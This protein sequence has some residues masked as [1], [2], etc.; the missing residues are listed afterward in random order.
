MRGEHVRFAFPG[1]PSEHRLR[2]RGEEG[3]CSRAA[4]ARVALRGT[5]G[6]AP[7]PGTRA[8]A[9]ARRLPQ[10]D[11]GRTVTVAAGRRAFRMALIELPSGATHGIGTSLTVGER[12]GDTSRQRLDRRRRDAASRGRACTTRGVALRQR[13]VRVGVDAATLTH[14]A[15]PR[16]FPAAVMVHGSGPQH[17]RGVRGLRRVPRVER[18]R[19]ARRRQARRRR[20]RR[21]VPGR[22]GHR[23]DDRHPRAGRA[24]GGALRRDAAADRSE[25]RRSLRRQPGRLD[26]PARGGARA[27]PCA[28]LALDLGPTA[29]V[30]RDRSTGARSPASRET[31]P[32]GTHAEMLAQVRRHGP[33]GFD[34]RPSLAQARDPA[35]SGCSATTTATSRPSSASSGCRR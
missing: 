28:G 31:P 7:R 17:A 9:A 15:R 18:R 2:R 27:V 13:E 20:V 1:L 35:S 25:A 23:R 11:G 6:L 3:A 21:D 10:R 4:F 26:H 16:P 33:S 22:R 8:R 29:T 12:L 30:G 34:P 19:R 14:A 5:F 32:S 24:G